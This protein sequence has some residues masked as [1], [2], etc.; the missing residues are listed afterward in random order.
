[1]SD[2]F[3]LHEKYSDEEP[4][5]A[6]SDRAFGCTVGSVLMVIGAAKGLA[7]GALPPVACFIF[8]AG[9]ALLLIGIIAP[10]RLSG[11]KGI[12]LK[13]GAVMAKVVNPIVMVLLFFL[14]VTPMALV[15]RIAGKRPLRLAPD[16]VA[17][18]YW[19]YPDTPKRETPSM[20][21][22]Y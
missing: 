13:V 15:M 10:S 22:Q 2:K 4:I 12:W 3:S 18:S 21:R 14:V 7:A 16:P 1:M 5:K 20:E 19:I 6:G 17:S 11:L 9:A 8:A